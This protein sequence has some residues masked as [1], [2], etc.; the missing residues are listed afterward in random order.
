MV[1]I[2]PDRGRRLRA[3]LLESRWIGTGTCPVMD[4]VTAGP[5]AGAR[6]QRIRMLRISPVS[7]GLDVARAASREGLRPRRGS[8]EVV[9]Q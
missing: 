5:A 4:P 7:S 3:D 8:Q 9:L 2:L 6:M 1:I